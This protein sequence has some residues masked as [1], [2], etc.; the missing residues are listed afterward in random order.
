MPPSFLSYIV[1]QHG[2]TFEDV[3]TDALAHVLYNSPAARLALSNYLNSRVTGLLPEF[4]SVET[5]VDT[6]SFGL[7]DLGGFGI[8][9]IVLRD[10]SATPCVIMEAKFTAGLTFH[11]P[12]GYLKFLET[13]RRS[14]RPAMLVFLVPESRFAHYERELKTRCVG[15]EVSWSTSEE[16][17]DAHLFIH[18]MTWKETLHLLRTGDNDF[19][20]FVKDLERMCTVAEPDKYEALSVLEMA[21]LSKANSSLATRTRNFMDL[22]SE[23]AKRTFSNNQKIWSKYN[24]AWGATWSGVYGSVAGFDAWIGFDAS[25]WSEHGIS[26]IWITFEGQNRSRLTEIHHRLASIGTDVGLF[27]HSNGGHLAVPILLTSGT[28]DEVLERCCQ[29][30][31]R[32]TA[33][34]NRSESIGPPVGSA[35]VS[36][37]ASL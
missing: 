13:Q 16:T 32:L 14:G 25:A 7:S 31:D 19:E 35:T 22:A 24:W 3:A 10:G 4:F 9:D 2:L 37:D 28:R 6:K 34:L 26:P 18:V 5:R 11:Q 36:S 17:R 27:P 23:I 30:V 33:L 12:L 21:E 29:Q 8:P 15:K 1:Q 20:I